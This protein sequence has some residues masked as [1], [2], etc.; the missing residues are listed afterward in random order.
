MP[1]SLTLTLTVAFSFLVSRLLQR[2]APQRLSSVTAY[3]LVGFMVG[4]KVGGLVSS[5]DLVLLRPFISLTLGVVGF[6]L[7]LPLAKR[8]ESVGVFEAGLLSTTLSILS[9]STSANFLFQFLHP[10]EIRHSGLPA[11]TLGAAGAATSLT[12][13][14]TSAM[15]FRA[16]G[17]VT[18]LVQSLALVGNLL[19]V[20][21]SGLAIATAGADTSAARLGLGQGMWLFASIGLGIVCG[22]L[23]HFFMRA[24]ESDERAFLGT[25]GIIIFTSGVASAMGISSLV[26]TVLAGVTFALAAGKN[27]E[28][29][30]NLE[31]LGRPSFIV[32]AILAGALW[33]P[34]S[35][36]AIVEPLIFFGLRF[37]VLR[38]ASS[39]AVRVVPRVEYVPRI[40]NG[41]IPMGGVA[42]AIG[43][44]YS[45]VA[46]PASDTV[47]NAILGSVVLTEFLSIRSLRRLWVDAGEISDLSHR[48]GGW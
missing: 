7:G 33:R 9:L 24:E 20:L 23:F 40:G 8:L 47:L 18:Q 35:W 6:V 46:L 37:L 14:R 28:R 30:Q 22:L 11:I 38:I 2:Y 19:A 13:L 16:S 21:V 42:I 41:L 48:K 10:A 31:Q 32:L 26:L 27:D 25:V 36:I 39:L 29:F 44:N 34:T 1:L 12:T 45:H 4:P 17:L 15:R 5:T 3:L 43:V